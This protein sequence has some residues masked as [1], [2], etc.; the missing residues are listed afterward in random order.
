[1]RRREVVVEMAK[2][3]V[4]ALQ[5][6]PPKPPPQSEPERPLPPA[7]HGRILMSPLPQVQ[8]VESKPAWISMPPLQLPIDHTAL[9]QIVVTVSGTIGALH[10]LKRFPGASNCCWK[11]L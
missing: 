7:L 10:A 11:P 4:G 9:W 2:V 6:G 5:V 1:M 3:W 8:I